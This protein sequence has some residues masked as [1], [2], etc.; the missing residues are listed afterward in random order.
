M[1]T[2]H[3][4]GLLSSRR[5]E[6]GVG[7]EMTSPQIGAQDYPHALRAGGV[8]SKLVPTCHDGNGEEAS[9]MNHHPTFQAAR[10]GKAMLQLKGYSR[11]GSLEMS[12]DAYLEHAAVHRAFGHIP[13]YGHPPDFGQ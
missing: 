2:T 8:F 13:R 6:V 3:L 1:A 12:G 11:T 4:S 9:D 5:V 7:V 10:M